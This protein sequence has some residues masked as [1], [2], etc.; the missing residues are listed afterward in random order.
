MSNSRRMHLTLLDEATIEERKYEI[1][2]KRK[3]GKMQTVWDVIQYLMPNYEPADKMIEWHQAMQ[4]TKVIKGGVRSGK[5][6]ALCTEDVAV[7]YI[8][9]PMTHITLAPT[10]DNMLQTVIPVF[11]EICERNGLQYTWTMSSQEFKIFHGRGK[12]DIATILC[13]GADAFFKGVTAA[14][15]SVNEPFSIAK[16]KILI[17]HERVSH[18]ESR[19]LSEVWGGTAEP[20]KM[21]WGYEYYDKEK[22]DTKEL[23]ADTITTYGNRHLAKEYIQKLE[24][25]YDAKMREVYMLGKHVNLVQSP[26][27]HQFGDNRLIDRREIPRLRDDDIIIIGFDFNV[28]H[29]CAAMGR[30]TAEKRRL[31]QDKEYQLENSNT[32]EL[33]NFIIDDYLYKW[34]GA[35]YPEELPL[36]LVTGDATGKSRKTS[37][38]RTDYKIIR[39]A[40]QA[41]MIKFRMYIP[42]KNPDV[43]DRIN[44]VNKMFETGQFVIA[45]DLK[46]TIRDRGLVQWKQGAVKFVVDKSKEDVTHLSDAGDYMALLAKRI[47]SSS[48]GEIGM[49]RREM[50]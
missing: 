30:I 25:K 8:N 31:F 26:V 32:E 15:G 38:Q 28:G 22:I 47:I 49:R 33:I 13:I 17:F 43:V 37:S 34:S 48:G 11:K 44:D 36:L 20:D 18:P 16:E 23:Y 24:R 40:L 50:R 1:E 9:R 35:P 27:Y 10:W 7:S 12:K 6:Y 45:N 42:E 4:L 46:G 5:T 3:R 21:N 14:S 29:M 19:R 39:D 2:S 41:A